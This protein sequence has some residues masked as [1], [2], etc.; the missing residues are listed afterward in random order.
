V[1]TP[2]SPMSASPT[3]VSTEVEVEA[4]AEH[5]FRIFTDGIGTWW[6]EGH[7]ILR[8]P[9]AEMVFEPYVG[10]HIIDRGTDGSECRWARVLVYE[11]PVRVCFSWDINLQWQIEN[12]PERAS[13]VEISFTELGPGRTR[14]VLTHRHLD[15][16]GEGW[17]GMRDAV[18]S[19]WS[20]TGFAAA[21]QPPPG[22]AALTE[23]LPTITDDEMRA[24]VAKARPYTVLVLHTTAAFAR[25]ACDAVVWEHGRRNMALVDAGLLSVVLPIADDSGIAGYG[26]FDA[27]LETTRR[28]MDDDPG[29][30]AGIFSVELHPVRGFPG[31]CLP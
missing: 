14:V 12:D 23:T 16:H 22:G 1:T 27:D 10:G 8:A 26:V 17:E 3:S 11:P 6:D 19:G 20:L 18:G 13:E 30:R 21:A 7:H 25:P 31:S 5:A 9:L 28:I 2:P 29:V 15:R 24:R 4:S